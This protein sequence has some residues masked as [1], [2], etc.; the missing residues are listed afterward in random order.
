MVHKYIYDTGNNH[1]LRIKQKTIELFYK[2][3]EIL[4]MLKYDKKISK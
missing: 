3:L 2:L 1:Y 4:N